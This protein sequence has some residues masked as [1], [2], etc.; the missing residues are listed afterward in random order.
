MIVGT[1]NDDLE[2]MVELTVYG[3]GLRKRK[4]RFQVDTG[5]N[6]FL[7]IPEEVVAY[8]KLRR[9]ELRNYLTLADGSVRLQHYH[10]CDVLWNGERRTVLVLALDGSPLIGMALMNGYDLHVSV[11]EG[12]AVRL[13]RQE[14]EPGG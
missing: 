4:V 5:F 7:V 10:E 2:A 14:P 11:R 13:T 8:L 1:V 6:D 12:G 3:Q 9:T